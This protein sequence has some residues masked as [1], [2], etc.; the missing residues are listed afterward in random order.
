MVLSDGARAD[1]V[2]SGGIIH[3]KRRRRRRHRKGC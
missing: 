2:H 3:Q 1:G